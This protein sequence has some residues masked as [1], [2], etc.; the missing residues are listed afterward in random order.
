MAV[1][2]KAIRD[3]VELGGG[4]VSLTPLV[5]DI[6]LDRDLVKRLRFLESV[7]EITGVGVTTNAAMAHRFSDKELAYIIGRFDRLSISV[8]GVD[9]EEYVAMTQ[10][11]TYDQMLNGIRR[12][13][14]ASKNPVMLQFRLLKNRTQASIGH[15]GFSTS[16]PA[17]TSTLEGSRFST[18]A[19]IRVLSTSLSAVVKALKLLNLTSFAPM[20][21]LAVSQILS[22]NPRYRRAISLA[23]GFVSWR[24][25]QFLYNWLGSV[26][27]P[28]LS[29]TQIFAKTT[30]NSVMH[31]YANWGIYNDAKVV[32]P[33]DATW[34]RHC[35]EARKEQCMIPLLACMVFSN[36]NVSFCPCDNYD[37]IVELRLRH[38]EVLSGLFL[39]PA[40][41]YDCQESVAVGK[42][43]PN[44]WRRLN[45]RRLPAF[46]YCHSPQSTM[47]EECSSSRE[48]P[49]KSVHP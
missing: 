41:G 4:Y 5:G 30:I 8:Y 9:K 12:V 42:S 10:R 14:L 45:T 23:Q 44:G 25:L 21:Q 28:D 15:D 43:S 36:G 31:T 20:Q 16:S 47:T 26:V 33:F 46:A 17:L 34:D 13:V 32:L 11:P 3:Y 48:P 37:D 7:P 29:L 1:F 19:G 2:E 24:S 6:F 35:H 40:F 49:Q 22:A 39:S 38:S 18:G 27:F